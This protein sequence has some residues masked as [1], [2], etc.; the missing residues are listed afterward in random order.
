MSAS[1][2]KIKRYFSEYFMSDL[3]FPDET[4][5]TDDGLFVRYE[6]YAKLLQKLSEQEKELE[7]VRGD[8]S[9]NHPDYSRLLKER[10]SLEKERDEL[11]EKVERYQQYWSS[12]TALTQELAILKTER[13]RMR[14]ALEIITEDGYWNYP[15]KEGGVSRDKEWMPTSP[16]I[17][18]Q[19]ALD[20]ALGEKEDQHDK[21]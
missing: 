12:V 21:T 3:T 4:Y 19:K 17:I 11:R 10:N 16:A 6:E 2:P 7:E 13:E 20:A 8:C 5:E 15:V 14:E 18:A 9:L 1:D